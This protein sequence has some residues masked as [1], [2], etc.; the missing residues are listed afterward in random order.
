VARLRAAARPFVRPGRR[1]QPVYELI[2]T[3]VQGSAG[4]DGNYSRDIDAAH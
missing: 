4:A 2:V 3:V 1:V